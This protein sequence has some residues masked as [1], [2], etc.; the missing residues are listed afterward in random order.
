MREIKFRAWSTKFN[1]FLSVGFHI[2]GETTLFDL[3]NQ[4]RIEELD[5]LKIT[6][7]TGL[8]DKNKKDIYEGDILSFDP[9]NRDCAFVSWDDFYS[10][11]CLEW[12]TG[13]RRRPDKESLCS[14]MRLEII[15]NIME[16]PELL[17][18]KQKS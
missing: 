11:F 1:K 15:G 7:F 9:E 4:H 16:N 12:P 14:D 8:K 18:K 13:K 2:I 17:D 5:T 10:G 6:Q 3:L